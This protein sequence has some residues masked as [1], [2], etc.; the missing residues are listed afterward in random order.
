MFKHKIKIIL[1]G[2]LLAIGADVGSA[3]ASFIT[4]ELDNTANYSTSPNS[5]W[6]L[7][8]TRF[9]ATTFQLGSNNAQLKNIGLYLGRFTNPAVSTTFSFALYNVDANNLP[10]GTALA[11][12]TSELVNLLFNS[13]S[14]QYPM[15]DF[16]FGGTLSTYLLSSGSKYALAINANTTA[17]NVSIGQ[18]AGGPYVGSEFTWVQNERNTA[19]YWYNHGNPYAM[20]LTVDNTPASAVPEPSTYALLCISLGVVGFVR[21]KMKMEN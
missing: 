10:T 7:R 20:K 11:S 15:Y 1:V 8:D 13:N 4:T 18:G 2:A 5:T 19:G 3:G 9:L 16:A 21:R 14:N 6:S 17:T 12:Y